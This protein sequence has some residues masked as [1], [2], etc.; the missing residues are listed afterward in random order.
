MTPLTEWTVD[1]YKDAQGSSPA[2]EFL[3]QLPKAEQADLLRV[4]DLLR[5]FGLALKLPHA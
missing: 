2:R 1:F 3:R 4:L 5:E